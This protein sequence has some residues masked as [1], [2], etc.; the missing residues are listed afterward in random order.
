MGAFVSGLVSLN[1]PVAGLFLLATPAQIPGYRDV[2][3]LRNEVPTLLI[4]GTQDEVCPIE[5][6]EA[7]ADKRSLPLLVLEDDHRLSASMD[8]I[9]QQFRLFLDIVMNH[10][11][12]AAQ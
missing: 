9:G 11:Q 3:D 4:H 7:F 2:F 5:Q 10:A 8:T 6:I 12:A 1:V